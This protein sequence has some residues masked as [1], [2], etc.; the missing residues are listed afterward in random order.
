MLRA[1]PLYEF[2]SVWGWNKK[3][4]EK[5]GEDPENPPDNYPALFALAPKF[6]AAGNIP[7]VQPWLATQANLFA[8]LYLDEDLQLHRAIPMFSEDR[9]QSGS[10]ARR[11]QDLRS[12]I[13]EGIK[14]GFWDPK[15]MNI[16]NEHDAFKIFGDGNVAT[17]HEQREPGPARATWLLGS[18]RRPPASRH[19]ARHDRLAPAVPTAS[20]SASSRRSRTRA[21]S[22]ARYNFGSEVEKAAATTVVDGTGALVHYPVARTSVVADPEVIKAIPLQP[23]VRSCRARAPDRPLVDPVRHRRR[24]STRSIAKM[25]SGEF[26]AAQAHDA[27]VKGCQ[28]MIIKYLSA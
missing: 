22:W 10:T 20:A 2:P 13:E 8:L 19:R 25:I 26:T 23:V 21:W 24:S 14:S 5:I 3:I 27:A 18:T 28:D 11:A 17:V 9:T 16:T 4:F 7:C 15:Y 12:S 1:L 6:E